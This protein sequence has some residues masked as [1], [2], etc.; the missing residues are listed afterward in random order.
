M[1]P[2]D[3]GAGVGDDNHDEDDGVD[4]M[5]VMM[6]MMMMM[7]R[8]VIVKFMRF[9]LTKNKDFDSLAVGL[10]R[11][12]P[13]N[14]ADGPFCNLIQKPVSSPHVKKRIDQV[15]VFLIQRIAHCTVTI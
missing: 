11:K 9:S 14:K 8:V 12:E 4:C 15:M 6:M 3:F 13:I 10:S 2:E 5:A 7:V 1:L